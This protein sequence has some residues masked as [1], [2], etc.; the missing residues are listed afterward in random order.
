MS[1]R[2]IQL[3]WYDGD[4][5]E[6]DYLLEQFVHNNNI[7]GIRY[8]G[9]ADYLK[10]ILKKDS[11]DINLCV[12][13]ANSPFK[14]SELVKICNQELQNTSLL[15]LSINKFQ[16]IPEPNL[17]VI[18]DYDT[19]IYQYLI[20]NVYY[21]LIN[22]TSGKNDGGKKFN[23]VHPLTRFYFCNENII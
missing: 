6:Q 19:A 15:Y 17:S 13:L 12:Y 10:P 18:E 14:F 11:Q 2:E 20:D 21:K 7:N 1:W 5:I 9:D 22:Y 3:N 16:A 23:W 8:L 4:T